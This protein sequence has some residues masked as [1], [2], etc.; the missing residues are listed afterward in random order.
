MYY[1]YSPT[2]GLS[3]LE[4]RTNSAFDSERAVYLTTLLPM[5]LMYGIQHFE[6]T[7]GFRF[8]DGQPQGMYYEEQFPNA[9]KKLYRGKSASLYV[10][11]ADDYQSTLKPHEAISVRPVT[12]LQEIPVP[13]LLAAL[14]SL[15]QAGQLEIIRFEQQSE[16]S[17]AWNRRAEMEVIL[18]HDL[19]HTPGPFA[20]YMKS[21]YPD[22]WQ[23]ALAKATSTEKL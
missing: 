22:S 14:L 20:D 23:D 8:Q 4:P 12:V 16:K 10:C 2:S 15:E 11:P 13:D 6:Y 9:L 1:H 5:A 17:L 21:T 7:Y 18:K 3:V 19:L